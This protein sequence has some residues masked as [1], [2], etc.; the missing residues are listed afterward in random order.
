MSTGRYFP[1]KICLNSYSFL[2][3]ISQLQPQMVKIAVIVSQVK[4]QFY[5]KKRSQVK[6]IFLVKQVKW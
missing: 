1:P 5:E 3:L 4:L 6:V 2:W